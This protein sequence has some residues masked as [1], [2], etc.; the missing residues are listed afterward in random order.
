M[1][2]PVTID[3]ATP[4]LEQPAEIVMDRNGIPHIR[5]ATRHDVFFAQ[6]FAA[7]RERLWQLDLWRKRG[8][9][10]LAAAPCA[11]GST[12]CRPARTRRAC[13]RCCSNCA[14]GTARPAGG[15]AGP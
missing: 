7:A 12:P 15:R 5:A 11:T 14:Q 13:W 10:R 9:G 3:I 4:G 1:P 8:L 6:G 2:D